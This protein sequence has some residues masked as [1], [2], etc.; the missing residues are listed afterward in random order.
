VD[1][2]HVDSELAAV[3]I[4]NK[5]SDRATTALECIVKTSPEVGLV[6]N[7]KR[8]LHITL[9]RLLVVFTAEWSGISYGLSHSDNSAVL[10]VKD[11][12]LLEDWAQHG[13]YNNRWRW[14][15]DERGVLVQ[16]LGEEVNTEEAVLA[17]G[18]GCSD[19][20]HLGSTSLEDHD[21]ANAHVVGWNGDGVG[22]AATWRGRHVGARSLA[23]ATAGGGGYL[24]V[25]LWAVVVVATV[26]NAV[27]DAV[28][29]V[30]E[31]V[32][33]SLIES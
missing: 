19:L 27:G 18:W 10:K 14:A 31:G 29:T 16:L 28:E 20:D 9:E 17:S 25:N 1:N 15:G 7:W 11:S 32:I 4:E 8:L 22:N 13:L 5:D 3:V 23:A 30:A 12:V 6:N 33:V 2:L 21:I 24:D 26:H